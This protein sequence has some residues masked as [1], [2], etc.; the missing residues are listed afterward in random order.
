VAEPIQGA[1]EP[2]GAPERNGTPERVDLHT[3]SRC[4]DGTLAPTALVELAAGRGVRMLALTDHDSI[5]GCEEAAAACRAHGIH[6]VPGV[7][8]SCRWRERVIHVVGLG[9]DAR[10]PR[11]RIHCEQVGRLRR[12]R[13]ERIALQLNALGLPGPDLAAAA[14]A[15]PSPTRTHLARALYAQG[16]ATSIAQAFEHYLR[17]E[18]PEHGATPWPELQAAVQCI[19]QAGGLAVLA[20]PHRYGLSAGGSRELAGQFKTAGG[21]GIE[22]SLAGM[23]PADSERAASLARRFTLAGSIGSDFHEPGLPWRPLGRSDKLPEA[24]TPVTTCLGP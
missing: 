10:Q 19:V 5:A 17:R 23:G 16:F 22:V 7:E 13:I 24:V 4:S 18:P 8:L 12:E 6:F 9:I 15:A 14:L 3:H 1:P 11:L 20:H 21:A 2:T